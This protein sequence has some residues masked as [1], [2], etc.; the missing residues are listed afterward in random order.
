MSGE[1]RGVRENIDRMV[2]HLIKH[3]QSL[4]RDPSRAK[5]IAT[6]AARRHEHGE[7]IRTEDKRGSR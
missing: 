1:K 6:D 4:A 3:D 5:K 7:Q 2:E